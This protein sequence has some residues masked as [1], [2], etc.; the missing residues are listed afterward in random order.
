MIVLFVQLHERYEFLWWVD[1][2]GCDTTEQN[3]YSSFLSFICLFLCS[4]MPLFV[5]TECIC[6]RKRKMSHAGPVEKITALRVFFFFFLFVYY[7]KDPAQT[8]RMNMHMLI[9]N[10]GGHM[11][12]GRRP[13]FHVSLFLLY[14]PKDLDLTAQMHM[15][16]HVDLE[17]S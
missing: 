13:L 16:A 6:L 15:H 11:F 2:F 17:L 3:V 10:F 14:R 1:F 8:V 12:L 4:L 7:C 9:W 5:H